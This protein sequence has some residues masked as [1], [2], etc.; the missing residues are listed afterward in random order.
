LQAFSD[1]HGFAKVAPAGKVPGVGKA[2]T[3]DGFHRLD[4]AG[5][6][7]VEEKAAAVWFV[8]D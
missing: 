6:E 8:D 5:V 7:A 1:L 3:L 2:G 4:P